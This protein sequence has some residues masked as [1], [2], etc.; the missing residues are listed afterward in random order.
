MISRATRVLP[1]LSAAMAMNLLRPTTSMTCMQHLEYGQILKQADT[2]G[3]QDLRSIHQYV[4][5][6]Y[7]LGPQVK[8]PCEWV[9]LH[10]LCIE[11][12][13]N[14]I[15]NGTSIEW[16]TE[17]SVLIYLEC[18]DVLLFQEDM[19][20]HKFRSRGRSI[21]WGLQREHFFPLRQV[22]KSWWEPTN[23]NELHNGE[24]QCL[25]V[26]QWASWSGEFHARCRK[27]R[28]QHWCPS[29]S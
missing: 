23:T 3:K 26:A 4:I 8:K 27:D 17:V 12:R 22:G 15:T 16:N 7:P 13:P 14:D 28:L 21:G 18:S 19:A 25:M 6:Q 29:I 10:E 5:H 11:I 2:P 9:L 1:V 20:V 24:V